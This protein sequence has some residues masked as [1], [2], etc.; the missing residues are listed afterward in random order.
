MELLK[1][2]LKVL[3]SFVSNPDIFCA[4]AWGAEPLHVVVE[5][6]CLIWT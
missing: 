2:W 4:K 6:G 5:V 1:A 3:W